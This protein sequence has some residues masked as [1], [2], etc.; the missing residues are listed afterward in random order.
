M[1]K[2]MPELVNALKLIADHQDELKE[3]LAE[4]P[5]EIEIGTEYWCFDCDGKEGDCEYT[6][7]TADKER[8]AIGNFYLSERQIKAKKALLL[9][10][11]QFKHIEEGERYYFMY[12]NNTWE[13]TQSVA[14]LTGVMHYHSGV[15]ISK[16]ST[17]EDRAKRLELLKEY[18]EATKEI[19]NKL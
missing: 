15:A 1:K 3:L 18:H 17:K 19:N 4:K 9:H 13:L 2:L 7:D 8:K 14:S 12:F 6:G 10:I 16:D 11:Y 5:Q